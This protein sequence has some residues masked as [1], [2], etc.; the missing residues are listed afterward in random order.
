LSVPID[1]IPNKKALLTCVGGKE[2]YR[3]PGYRDQ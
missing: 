3:G 1:A 2:V